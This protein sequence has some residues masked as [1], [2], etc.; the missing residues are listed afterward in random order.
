MNLIAGL[1]NPGNRYKNT[2][3]NI[4]FLVI[5]KLAGFFK[6]NSFR[7]EED[8][9]LADTEYNSKTIALL[10]PQTYMN[11]SGSALRQFYERYEVETEDMLIIYDDVNIGFGT[12]R[13]RPSGSDGGQK[14]M[15]S[16]IYEFENDNIARLRIGT[17]NDEEL[18]KF[19]V[20]G[21]YDLAGFVLSDFTP[22]EILIKV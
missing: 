11:L 22:G 20:D 14:G 12:L 10:K 7:S 4:G 21:K 16:I 15:Q 3:H 5:D 8:Y 13:M 18:E 6:I 17:K 9:L 19:N 1:G 2:R